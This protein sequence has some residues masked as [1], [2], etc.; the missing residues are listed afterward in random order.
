MRYGA[1]SP[2]GIAWARVCAE[3]RRQNPGASDS[4][5]HEIMLTVRA[6]FHHNWQTYKYVKS[7]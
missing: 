4:E 6:D 5:L 2:C 7:P 3:I 1:N